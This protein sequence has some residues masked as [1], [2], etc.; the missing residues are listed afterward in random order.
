MNIKKP[1]SEYSLFLSLDTYSTLAEIFSWD[2]YTEMIKYYRTI[3]DITDNNMKYDMWARKYSQTVNA[4]LCYYFDW[5]KWPLTSNTR[6]VCAGL[7]PP[8][9]DPLKDFIGDK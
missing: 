5:F 9:V 1:W 4:N 6:T 3:P 8:P 2:S 7:P